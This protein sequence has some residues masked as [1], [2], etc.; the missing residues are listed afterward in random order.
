MS[1]KL[2]MNAGYGIRERYVVGEVGFVLGERDTEITPYVTWCFRADTPSEYFWGHY[3]SSRQDAYD[4]Y[5]HRIE[6]E[7]VSVYEHTG[8]KPLLPPM[9]LT[10]LQGSGNLVTIQRGVTGFYPS[11]YESG[12][13]QKNREI[14][15]HMN[16]RLKV[17]KAQEQAMA[18]GSMLG[19]DVPAADPRRYDENGSPK[20]AAKKKN[21]HER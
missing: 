19:W 9:C 7:V 11:T 10:V 8:K 6:D 2:D 21:Q 18:C 17:S 4:D 1:D 12:D 3:C 16:E 14:A 5:L 20:R 15:D 13:A